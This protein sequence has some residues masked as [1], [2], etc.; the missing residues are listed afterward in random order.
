MAPTQGE[1]GGVSCALAG[2]PEVQFGSGGC[3]VRQVVEFLI[4]DAGPE[5]VLTVSSAELLEAQEERRP[6]L[7]LRRLL[8]EETLWDVAKQYRTDEA[9][10]RTVN[11][12]EDDVHPEKM[13]LIPRVR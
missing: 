10:L 8:P 12:L 1:P 11:Q 2:S 13:L 9:L 5:P 3:D 4:E 7:V 6:S